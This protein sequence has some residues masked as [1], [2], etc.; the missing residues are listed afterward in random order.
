MRGYRACLIIVLAALSTQLLLAQSKS[1]ATSPRQKFNFNSNWK[2]FVGDP[3]GAD[4]VS[5]DD[6]NWK[7][8]TLPYAWNED[9]AFRKGNSGFTNWGGVVSK[10]FQASGKRC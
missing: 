10:A 7:I 9:D 1:L 8:V 3:K 6:S 4:S 5:Y 2:V